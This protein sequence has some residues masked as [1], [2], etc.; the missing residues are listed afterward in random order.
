MDP[1]FLERYDQ[2]LRFIREMGAEF[3]KRYP[4][5]AG[6]LDL[7]S[8]ECADPYVERLLEGFAFLTARI[9]LKMDAEFPAFTRHLLEMVYPDYLAPTPSMAVVQFEP[10]LKGGVTEEGFPIP[11]YS[12]LRSTQSRKGRSACRFRTGHDVQLW[13]VHLSD[14]L[15]FPRGAAAQHLAPGQT[16]VRSA[17]KLTLE[18]VADIPFNDLALD[19][20]PVYLH[21]SV[22]LPGRIYELL[23]AHT[24][25]IVVKPA[26][27][28]SGWQER[29]HRRNLRP[30][31]FTDDQALLPV[32]HRSFQGYRLLREYFALPERFLFVEVTGLAQAIKRCEGTALDIIILLDNAQDELEGLLDAANFRLYCTPVINLFPKRTDRIHLT[33][34]STEHHV[35]VDKTK[36]LD[37]EIFSV[38]AIAGYASASTDEQVFRPFYATG[39]GLSDA[40]SRFYT[41]QRRPSLEPVDKR[42]QSSKS[43][44]LG[45]EVFVSLVD[46]E[47]APYSGDLKQLGVEALC[48]NRDLTQFMLRGQASPELSLE[49]GAPVVGVRSLSRYT[50]PKQ[51]FPD[52]EY[53]WR[54]ISHLALNYLTLFD[55]GDEQG[56]EALKEL[57]MLYGDF[58][59]PTIQKQIEGLLSV[60]ARRVVRRIPNDGPMAFGR[61]IEVAL[62][63]DDLAFPG[64]GAFLFGAVLD[65]F[66]SKYTSINSFTQ[67]VA[68]TRER[69]EIMQW[70]VRTG[71]RT[72]I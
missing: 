49:I 30:L 18:T 64:A 69:G 14:A 17:L 62:F 72:V 20:L 31:G 29:L 23:L 45:S 27:S 11:R 28:S 42:D 59:E 16:G 58:S 15:Y 53:A 61:G 24:A 26:G 5:V 44:Y 3:A 70:P 68:K 67:T 40:Q 38:G 56:A 35:V 13:P 4:K 63:L 9:Q 1:R 19:R 54:L 10:D 52:G 39:G 33:H 2:E 51:A 50:E 32:S 7:G 66:F 55:S 71:T 41:V 43:R 21:G 65:R 34:K 47:Q 25:E 36:P 37:F 60:S 46:N 6:R 22:G 57:L 8:M 12:H 48:T